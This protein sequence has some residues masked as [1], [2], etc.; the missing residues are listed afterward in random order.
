MQKKS[1]IDMICWS[2]F[3][4]RLLFVIAGLIVLTMPSLLLA[5]SVQQSVYLQRGPVPVQAAPIPNSLWQQAMS[6]GQPVSYQSQLDLNRSELV[7]AEA[8]GGEVVDD[9]T[10][11]SLAGDSFDLYGPVRT[12]AN[13]VP[14]RVITA[15]R[16]S[17]A[18]WRFNVD[19]LSLNRYGPREPIRV[20]GGVDLDI[21]KKG[22]PTGGV[23]MSASADLF[24]SFDLEFAWVGGIT[25]VGRSTNQF[26]WNLVNGGGGH[27]YTGGSAQ[28][29]NGTFIRPNANKTNFG[30]TLNTFEMNTKFRWVG[31]STPFTGAWIFG[32]R[33]V[34]FTESA[35]VNNV[36]LLP[37]V[38]G[39]VNTASTARTEAVNNLWGFQGGGECFWAVFRGVMVGGNLKGGIYGNLAENSSELSGIRGPGGTSLGS[40][41]YNYTRATAS[42]FGEANVMVNAHVGKN[43]YI[44]G[45]YTGFF[46]TNV[47]DSVTAVQ[48]DFQTVS[49]KSNLV[50]SGFY[51]GL[52]WK[53]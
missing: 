20:S 53:Y 8:V 9:F 34:R 48:Q 7:Q 26:N 19:L 40:A 29:P 25:W 31:A 47:T 15:Q 3:G 46:L 30:S 51:G 38:T 35:T 1:M 32:P 28:Q 52:E 33:Y 14:A 21:F 10:A 39:G 36:T 16:Y 11:E 2:K 23:R 5:Q 6:Y 18:Y 4:E 24:Y 12:W 27:I 45:G 49:A 22:S 37:P 42:F 17:D 43:C 44:R 13:G 41:E 50:A